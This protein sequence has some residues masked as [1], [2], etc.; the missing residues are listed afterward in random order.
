MKRRI[1]TAGAAVAVVSLA[2]GVGVAMAA[3]TSHHHKRHV[4]P[5]KPKL[6]G[7]KCTWALSTV[8]PAGQANVDQPPSD[9]DTYGTSDCG[10]SGSGVVHTSFTVPD[11]GDTVGTYTAYYGAGTVSGSFDMSPNESPPISDTGFYSQTWTGTLKLTTTTGSYLGVKEK[12]DGVLN[13]STA[14]SGVHMTCVA[15]IGLLIP[16]APTATGTGTAQPQSRH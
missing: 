4:P 12:K 16:P 15:R 13:C 6:V 3:T 2:V 10:T 8:P 7:V 1:Y 14:D 5:P 9:G 11:S